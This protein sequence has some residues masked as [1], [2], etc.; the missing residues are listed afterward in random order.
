MHVKYISHTSVTPP[1]LLRQAVAIVSTAA[2]A[3]LVL[4]FSVVFFVIIFIVGAFGAAY[5]WWKTRDLRKQ[6]RNFSAREAAMES[7][8]FD[9][10]VLKGEVIEGEAIRVHDPRHELRR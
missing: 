3:G 9:G 5:L 1:S 4:M 10:E 6:M 8:V 7:G 2:L